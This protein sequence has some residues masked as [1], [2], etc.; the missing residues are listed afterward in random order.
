M[1][2]KLEPVKVMNMDEILAEAW[3]ISEMF[4]FKDF[5]YFADKDFSDL[6]RDCYDRAPEVFAKMQASPLLKSY[7]E[8]KI[9]AWK[10]E[11]RCSDEELDNAY[12]II[13]IDNGI[14]VAIGIFDEMPDN[15]WGVANSPITAVRNFKT[16]SENI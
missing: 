6:S 5:R 7:A 9:V 11:Y 2:E 1:F 16:M 15:S 12:D 4:A 10:S 3:L 13:M 14:E 8:N